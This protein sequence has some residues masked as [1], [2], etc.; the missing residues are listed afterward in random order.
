LNLETPFTAALAVLLFHERLG[1][2]GWL[3]VAMLAAAAAWLGYAPATSESRGVAVLGS[4]LVTGASLCWAFDNNLTQRLSAKD[5][6]AVVACK[7]L[8]AGAVALLLARVMGQEFPGPR[9]LLLGLGLGA[10]SYGASLVLFV[11]A[12][13]HLGAAR[14][15][16]LFA[17]APFVGAATALAVLHEPASPSLLGASVVMAA[18]VALLLRDRT[19]VAAGPS[20]GAEARS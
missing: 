15:T 8:G 6:F 17:T 10:L 14:A 2:A 11:R 12:L 1:A 20:A 5:P 7:G 4:A 19:H 9:V 18:G 16:A 13:R 3:A